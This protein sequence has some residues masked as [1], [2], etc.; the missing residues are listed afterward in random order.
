[1][2]GFDDRNV[3]GI[4][5]NLYDVR[6][7]GSWARRLSLFNG[8]SDRGEETY[9][10]FG[11]FA[12]MREWKGKR[13]EN[14]VGQKS[15]AIANKIYES[16]LGIPIPMLDRD[17]SGL[18]D[19]Y[20]GKYADVVVANHWEDLIIDLI[21]A[22]GGST[23]GVA[24]DGQYYFDTDH[25]FGSETAQKNSVTSSEVAAL[26]V[27]TATAPT[28]T[29]AAAAILGLVGYMMTFKDD[30]GR[31]VN[32]DA[33][34]FIIKVSTVD[35]YAACLQAVT[36]NLL[37]G[38]VDNPINGLRMGGLTFDVKLVADL[39][40][41]TTKIRIFREDSSFGAFILQEEMPIKTSLL[42]RDS[43][44]A[45]QTNKILLALDGRRGAGYGEW[46]NAIEGTLS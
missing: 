40:S 4:F 45:I 34:K 8:A 31:Y 1:M 16:S 46:M 32:G 23:L 2:P 42:G 43:E 20:I 9:G 15:I 7:E 12:K 41:A 25:Q 22:G 29:E 30:Q 35:L 10:L 19:A 26:N 11:G 36:A 39:T 21:N 14:V 28:P 24:Y 13:Q 6:F 37:T 18:L 38:P 27:T 17:K 33:R 5:R 3:I 44:Y